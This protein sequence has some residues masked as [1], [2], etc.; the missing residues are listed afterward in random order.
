MRSRR[1]Y[2]NEFMC[3]VNNDITNRASLKPFNFCSKKIKPNPYSNLFCTVLSYKSTDEYVQ[4]IYPS[5]LP[6]LFFPSR[7][8]ILCSLSFFLSALIRY[9]DHYAHNFR[10]TVTHPLTHSLTHHSSLNQLNFN[11]A[12]SRNLN[13][14]SSSRITKRQRI[15]S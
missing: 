1:I 2:M 13:F 7:Q 5:S 3:R 12:R 14:F 8:K 10:F 4:Y 6:S 15:I 9:F 11:S